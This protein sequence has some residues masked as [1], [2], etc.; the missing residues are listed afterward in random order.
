MDIFEQVEQQP[1]NLLPR[2]GTVY[3][4]GVVLPKSKADHYFEALLNTI[5]WRHD[6]AIMFGRKKSSPS[7]KSPGM[8]A[9][10]LLIPIQ[11]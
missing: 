7:A 6:R 1:R 3:Y 11:K 10:L 4:Y 2:D 5:A 9:S 8:E